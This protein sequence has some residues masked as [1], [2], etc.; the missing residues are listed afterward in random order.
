MNNF[1]NLVQLYKKDGDI[2]A[3]KARHYL[4]NQTSNSPLDDH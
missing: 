4:L 2:Y 3:L 1:V